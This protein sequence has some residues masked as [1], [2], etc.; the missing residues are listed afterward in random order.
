MC[1]GRYSSVAVANSTESIT[2]EGS[3]ERILDRAA[4]VCCDV[5]LDDQCWCVAV[6]LVVSLS[7]HG[8]RKTEGAVGWRRK[9]WSGFAFQGH[10]TTSFSRGCGAPNVGRVAAEPYRPGR[11]SVLEPIVRFVLPGVRISGS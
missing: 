5:A 7:V 8:A 6:R 11:N 2:S 1:P 9:R 10:Q 3:D 4:H